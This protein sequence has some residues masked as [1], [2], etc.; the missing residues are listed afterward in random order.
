MAADLAESAVV[1]GA[2]AGGGPPPA[3]GRPQPAPHVVQQLQS[4][5]APGAQQVYM[6]PR[7]YM[8]YPAAQGG[9]YVVS[10]GTTPGASPAAPAA[11]GQQFQVLRQLGPTTPRV[12]TVI[13]QQPGT[14]DGKPNAAEPTVRQ[15]MAKIGRAHV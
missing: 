4:H 12:V 11:A 14:M 1:A 13:A 15:H 8:G 9:P 10:Y 6:Q 3:R 2:R 5:G 7:D